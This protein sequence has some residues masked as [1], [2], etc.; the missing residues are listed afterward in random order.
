MGSRNQKQTKKGE[1]DSIADVYED[2]LTESSLRKVVKHIKI[3]Q[4]HNR[5]YGHTTV[6]AFS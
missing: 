2:W 1:K 3:K 4:N 5:L 6:F